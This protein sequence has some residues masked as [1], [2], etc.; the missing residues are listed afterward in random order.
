MEAAKRNL[1]DAAFSF[2]GFNTRGNALQAADGDDSDNTDYG[3]CPLAV[4][5]RVG[6]QRCSRFARMGV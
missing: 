1:S 4:A 2:R 6:P 3:W 5:G